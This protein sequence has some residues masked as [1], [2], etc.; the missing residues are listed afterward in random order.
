MTPPILNAG[1]EMTPAQRWQRN[2]T[3]VKVKP[4]A[5][6]HPTRPFLTRKDFTNSDLLLM[7]FLVG[8]TLFFSIW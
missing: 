5:I 7:G 6:V 4:R 3:Y 8:I 2:I 1:Y